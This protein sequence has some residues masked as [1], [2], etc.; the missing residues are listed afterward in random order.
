MR[1]PLR[2]N[3]FDLETT[4]AASVALPSKV[5]LADAVAGRHEEYSDGLLP[6]LE[7]LLQLSERFDV[8]VARWRIVTPGIGPL[9]CADHRAGDRDGRTAVVALAHQIPLGTGRDVTS[10]AI[11]AESIDHV[12]KASLAD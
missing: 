2:W 6:R 12:G 10:E 11:A 4:I 5:P 8:L 9:Q 3:R 7:Q 1:P